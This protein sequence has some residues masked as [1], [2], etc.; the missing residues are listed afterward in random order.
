MVRYCMKG[1]ACIA[2]GMFVVSSF[3]V[4]AFAQLPDFQV[5]ADSITFSN[6]TPVEGEEITISVEVKNVG[7][8]TQTMN[9]DLV[10]NLYEGDPETQPL[11]IPCT[12]VIFELKPRQTKR[13]KVQWQPPPGQTTLY[14]VVNPSGEKH[15]QES[16]A[17][18]NVV[19]ATLVAETRTFPPATDAQIRSAIAKGVA[20]IEAQQGTHSRTCLQCGTENPLV[21]TCLMPLCGASLKGLAENLIPGDAWN[22]GEDQTQETALALQALLATGHTPAHPSVQK[23]LQFLLAQNWNDFAVYQYAVIIPALV[24]TQDAAYR[25]R[26]QFAVNQLV[27]KQLPVRD[28]EFVDPRDDGGWGYGYTADGA[29]MNMVIYALYAAKQWGVDI[30]QDTWARA[31]QWIRRN[32][33]ETGGWLYNL[34]DDGSRWAIGVYGSMT[35]TGLWALRACGVSVEDAQIQKGIAWIKK[36]WTLTRN[37]GSNSWLYYYLLSLQR[38]CDIPPTLDTLAGHNWY[39]EIAGMMVAQQAPDGR[40]HGSVSD[41]FATC[42]AVMSLSHSLVGPTSPNIG[43]VPR[44]LRFSPS[45][46]RVGEA[47]LLSATLRNTGLPFEGIL[48]V[49]FRVK[50]ENRSGTDVDAIKVA[51]AEVFWT[52]T[53]DETTVSANWVPKAEG[54]VELEAKVEFEDVDESDNIASSPVT[55]Y[56]QSTAAT[57]ERLAPIKKISD[58]VYQLGSVL[59]NMNERKVTVPGEI[60]IISPESYIEFFACGQLGKTHESILMLDVEPMHLY[61]ALGMLE[62]VPGRNLTGLGDP[63]KPKGTAAE[64]WVEWQRHVPGGEEEVVS[65]RAETLVWN[66]FE[67]RPMQKTAWI[68]TGGRI[69]KNQLTAQL[70]HNIIAVYRDPDSLFNHPL[71]GGTDDRTYRVNTDVIPPKG[72]KVKLIIR[73]LPA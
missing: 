3:Y 56:P 44:S 69:I 52:P 12:D 32:Q 22:F 4:S 18:N 25:E 31:E 30:P 62:M 9:E 54:K 26:I 21:L 11:Q 38:F 20:W 61:I 13:V 29:H 14:A 28:S 1:V 40:W 10:V 2:I 6:P 27:K 59:C 73:P 48:N 64:V 42:F 7:D 60:N 17:G 24:A 65:H 58:G 50:P 47:T 37:P 63:H 36:H 71:P 19:H 72:T 53:L 34:V 33:T 39:D 5:S 43:I 57:D 46:P 51:E 67:A 23:G 49:E 35:A 41:F 15:I 45:A 55:V 66:L 8:A 16:D 68:F 70:R